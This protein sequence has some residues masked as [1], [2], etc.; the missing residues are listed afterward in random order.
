MENQEDA[1]AEEF[2]HSLKIDMFSDEVFVFT[3]RGDVVNLPAGATPI[4]FAYSIHSAVGNRMVGAKV[5]GRIVGY[6]Y[7]LHNGDIV[8]VITSKTARGPSRD[9]VN[10]AKSSEARSKIRQWFK[11]ERRDENIAQGRSSF[12]SEL[13]HAGIT[14]AQLTAPDMLPNVLKRLPFKTLDELYAAIGYGGFTSLKAVN[15]IRELFAHQSKSAAAEKAE[16]AAKQQESK[17]V[18][19][20]TKSTNGIIVEGLDNCLVKFSK[21]CT[22]VPGDE[23]V[24]FITRGY[25]VSVHRKDCPNTDPKRYSEEDLGRFIAVSWADDIKDSYTTSLEVV[26]KDRTGLIMDIST[27]FSTSKIN[28]ENMNMRATA[29]GFAII[30]VTFSIT[31]ATQLEQLMRKLHQISNVMDVR[32]PAG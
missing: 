18:V 21:C 5:N 15:R 16:A 10:I 1:D 23:I 28:V 32:R 4:D 11:K 30:T 27:V 6:D 24:G 25:G 26:C 22:P 9:W 14:M 3:P 13:K 31:D 12:E 17:P 8:E 19:K 20:H 7:Q 29:D 2:I